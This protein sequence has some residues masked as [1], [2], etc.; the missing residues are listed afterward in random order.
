MTTP[1]TYATVTTMRDYLKVLF[2]QKAVLITC[3]IT[4][5]ATVI[6]GLQ[7]KTPVY[8]A[9][10]KLLISAEKQ[11]E[12]PYF[13]DIIGYRNTEI[14]LTQ[15][16]IVNSNPVLERAV[17][18]TGLF[19][20]PLDYE[21][22]FSAKLKKPLIEFQV[23]L[24]NKKLQG[25]TEDQKKTLLFRYALEDLRE[26]IKIEPV[27][28]TN[29]FTISV[30]DYSPVGAA[31]LANVISRS[32]II[33]DLEQ[34]L[35]DLQLKYGQSHLAYIQLKDSIDKMIKSLNGQP[36]A[37]V[38]A[39]GPA[40]VKIIEQANVPLKPVGPSDIVY[41]I[42]AGFMSIFLG[43]LLAFIFEY[44]DQSF[45]SPQEIELYL[46][47]MYLGFISHRR[48]K[49]KP[50]LKG[51]EKI[52]PYVLSFQTLAEQF[53]LIMRDKSIKSFLFTSA[54]RDEGTTTVVTNLATVFSVTGKHKVLIIDANI[55]NPGIHDAFG[56][57]NNL[58]LSGVIE[59]KVSFDESLKR[60]NDNL[61]LLRAGKSDL[62]P[63]TMLESHM[64][65]EVFR[66]AKEKFE[67]VLVDCAQL[68]DF[69]DSVVLSP[70]VD[71]TA[72]VVNEGATRR[73]VVQHALIPLTQAK[74][75]VIGA[76]L[77]NRSFVIP[78]A[79]YDRV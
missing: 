37:N 11:V 41:L 29:I 25:L 77:N 30:K 24:F 33:F 16:E 7:L 46:N 60:L 57:I 28:D 67:I 68:R 5:M 26:H 39:I 49:E 35:A 15:S 55:R 6:I 78:K 47:L 2:R 75:N 36:L 45:K 66:M 12:G 38:E 52:T 58:G 34:Q 53:Y 21:N 69:K 59:G 22:R 65:K 17:S 8:E 50:L 4:V 14:A 63:L 27:R 72:I 32:Y 42:L 18:S 48:N 3:I 71:A 44:M 54:E 51:D 23:K 40:S 62:N 20:R 10:V 13:R 73:Q 9:T 43:I 64:I 76:I 19:Q 74:T 56:V 31:I 79:I 70:L 61:F 1:D